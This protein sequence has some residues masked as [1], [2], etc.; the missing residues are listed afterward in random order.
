MK[1]TDQLCYRAINDV[2]DSPEVIKGGQWTSGQREFASVWCII[3][4]KMGLWAMR[5]RVY[6]VY[7]PWKGGLLG[8]TVRPRLLNRTPWGVI[9]CLWSFHAK[10]PFLS[11][12]IPGRKSR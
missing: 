9:H 1:S 12:I 10:E 4:G 8:N 5:V 6:V 7:Y 2:A 11:T 3:P